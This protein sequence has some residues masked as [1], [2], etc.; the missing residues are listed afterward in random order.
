M[1]SPWGEKMQ[2]SYSP[3][4]FGKCQAK[5]SKTD[6]F[7]VLNNC[8][9]AHFVKVAC[10][11]LRG[12][13]CAYFS[14]LIGHFY[15][16]PSGTNY[17]CHTL[18]YNYFGCLLEIGF[19]PPPPHNGWDPWQKERYW[20]VAPWHLLIY[21]SIHSLL[22]SFIYSLISH[23]LVEPKEVAMNTKMIKTRCLFIKSSRK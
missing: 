10:E 18:L 15:R 5:P 4:S 12:R 3:D 19:E 14:K 17:L 23:T 16:V 2:F 1:F 11:F 21:W 9:I 7:T 8:F 6:S 20:W 22:Y 13:Y